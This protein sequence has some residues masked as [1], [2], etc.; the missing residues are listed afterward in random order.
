LPK[1]LNSLLA[2]HPITPSTHNFCDLR[3]E[4]T[5]LNVNL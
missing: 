2:S 4:Q 3:A 1:E 5:T